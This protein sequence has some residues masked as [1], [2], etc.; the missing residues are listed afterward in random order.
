MEYGMNRKRRL[1]WQLYPSYL[2]IVLVSLVIVG[3]FAPDHISIALGGLF[4]ALIASGIG[5]LVSR[6]ISR[7]VEN[8][9]QS[10]E[11]LARGDLT[12]RLSV[13]NSE[14][15]GGLAVAINRMAVQLD[16]RIKTIVR[17][18]N[19]L[20]AILSSMLEGVMAIDREER[21][22]S[23]NQTA[24]QMFNSATSELQGQSIQE[25]I[26]NP[27]L[28]RFVKKALSSEKPVEDDIVLYQNG[29]RILHAHSAPLRDAGAKEDYIGT[30]LVLNDVTKLRHLE[31]IRRDF[32]ANVSHEI[33]TPLTAIKGFVET[34]HHG[35]VENPGEV[36]RFLGIIEKHVNRL[37]AIIEDLMSLSRIEQGGEREEIKLKK[38]RIKDVVYAAI[39]VCQAKAE[40]K[41][42]KVD[43]VCKKEITAKID[44]TLLE[45]AIINLLDNAIKYSRKKSTVQIEAANAKSK[46][47]VKIKDC[48]IGIAREHLSRLFERFYRV[49]KARSRKLGGTGL[50]L[51]IVKHIVKVHNGHVA[52]E[53][54]P[55]KGSTFTIYLPKG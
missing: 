20:E 4:I 15:L 42:I 9:K 18:R 29:E 33:K 13:P 11:R 30:L 12:H 54:T 37:V 21:I 53:S 17:Q 48:G 55:G 5:F 25:V 38:G 44:S 49:D 28:Q 39:Q 16:D 31:N 23:I 1:F 52:V 50:G 24:T 51:A 10:T 6:R 26:R 22:I 7:P 34:I 14:E 41:N 40:A 8:M 36:K 3:Q 2:L 35:A 27:K 19:E 43:S 45:Q 32:V 47:V 46:V